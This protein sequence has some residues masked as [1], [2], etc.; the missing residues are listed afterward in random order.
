MRQEITMNQNNVAIAKAF[1]TAFGEKNIETMEKYVHPDYQLIT[2]L[3]KLQGKEACL[4][5]A[6]S[7]MPFFNRLTIRT[8]FGRE[9]KPWSFTI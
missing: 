4:E 3:A 8:T 5:A 2:P 9:I 6:K 7:F 1:Y